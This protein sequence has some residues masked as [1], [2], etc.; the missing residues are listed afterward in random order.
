MRSIRIAR[1]MG[2]GD[3]IAITKRTYIAK[4]DGRSLSQFALRRQ[5]SEVRA[6]CSNPARADPRGGRQVNW[7]P[8][9]DR[10]PHQLDAR[11]LPGRTGEGSGPNVWRYGLSGLLLR[12]RKV[13]NLP[14]KAPTARFDI[15]T[16]VM[17][18]IAVRIWR[19]H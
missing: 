6:A 2:L 17:E 13:F 10:R 18:D 19:K 3:S 9:R 7:R 4:A 16:V 12:N 5:T 8:Y 11:N 1:S 15:A 14:Q